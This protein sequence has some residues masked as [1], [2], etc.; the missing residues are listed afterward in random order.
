MRAI[1]QKLGFKMHVEM[2]DQTV[3]AEL[4]L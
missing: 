1:C 3:R 2:E 4:A